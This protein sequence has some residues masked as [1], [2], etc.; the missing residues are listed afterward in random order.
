MI[1]DHRHKIFERKP[2]DQNKYGNLTSPSRS[3]SPKFKFK[4]KTKKGKGK[5]GLLVLSKI[6]VKRVKMTPPPQS[7]QCQQKTV[8]QGHHVQGTLSKKGCMSLSN[9]NSGP[10]G[11]PESF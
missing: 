8:G 9:S 2:F 4:A 5:F 6:L 10:V 3:P 1:D 11:N 7:V